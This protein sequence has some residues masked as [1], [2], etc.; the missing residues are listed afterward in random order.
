M[1]E[2][3][4][5]TLILELILLPVEY[6]T[7]SEILYSREQILIDQNRHILLDFESIDFNATSRYRIRNIV[8][9]LYTNDYDVLGKFGNK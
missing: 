8:C 2:S 4:I 5:W 1:I 9:D 7:E 6:S 3:E